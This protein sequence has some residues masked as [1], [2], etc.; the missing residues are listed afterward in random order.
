MTSIVQALFDTVSF[1]SLFA[2]TALGIAL[3][4]GVMR[5]INFAHG[6]LIMLG[7]YTLLLVTSAPLPLLF[8]IAIAAAVV[9][10]VGM[11]RIAFRPVRRADPSTLLVTSFA[12]SFLVQ[13]LLMLTVGGRSKS[14]DIGGDV[15]RPIMLGAAEIPL[16]DIVTIGISVLVVAALWLFLSKTMIGIQMRAAADDFVMARLAGIRANRVIASAFALS[17]VLAGV[18]SVLYCARTGVLTPQ[19][20]MTPVLIGFVAAVL[21]GVGSLV[22]AMAGGFLMGALTVSM[23]ILLPGSIRSYRDAFVFVLVIIVL[24]IRPQGLFPGPGSRGRV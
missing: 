22:G 16:L 2:L 6:E 3:I 15:S 21:G 18:V 14:L 8:L 1:G 11:E 10:A 9:A 24:L 13:N 12:V 20:G 7:A 5:M 19:L 17:G 23:Q 4:F